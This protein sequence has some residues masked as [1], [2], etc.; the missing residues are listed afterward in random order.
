MLGVRGDFLPLLVCETARPRVCLFC[1]VS[2]Q[3]SEY[4][5]I[6]KRPQAS[7]LQAAIRCNANRANFVTSPREVYSLKNLVVSVDGP[8]PRPESDR[9]SK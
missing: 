5:S 6:L 4:Q 7:P 8:K 3:S 9:V 1:N 2:T